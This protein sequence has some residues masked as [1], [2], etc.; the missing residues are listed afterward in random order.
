MLPIQ[1]IVHPTDFSE[2]SALAFRLACSLARD[3]EAR[4][5]VVHVAEPP[6]P[7]YASG[8]VL[9]QPLPS[10]EPLRARL[11]AMI[12]QQPGV[13]MEYRLVDGSAAIEILRLAK[14][15]ECNL[16]IMGTHGR[17]GLGRLLM[18]SVAEH[19]VRQAPCPVLTVKSPQLAAATAEERATAFV[20][21]GL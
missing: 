9:P 12:G 18:G 15:V 4:L 2:G 16:I 7:L 1:T 21:E 3:Y 6:L 8:V 17:T 14:E 10:R 11:Q 20:G 13:Q 5:V 19:V